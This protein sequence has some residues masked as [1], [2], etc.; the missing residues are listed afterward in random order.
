[1]SHH[2]SE[3]ELKWKG[4]LVENPGST[5]IIVSGSLVVC[6]VQDTSTDLKPYK[7]DLC[8]EQSE[9]RHKT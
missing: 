5:V 4:H 8:Y 9:P 2:N 3:P 1:M 7:H 6:T